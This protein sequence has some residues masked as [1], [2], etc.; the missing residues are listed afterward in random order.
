[1]HFSLLEWI[2][3]LAATIAVLLF[4]VVVMARGSDEPTMRRSAL[5]LSAYCGLAVCF[6]IWTGY[7]HGRQFAVRA[8]ATGARP[9]PLSAVGL[10]AAGGVGGCFG[11]GA[12]SSHGRQFAV[13]FFAG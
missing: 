10:W 11:S 8:R 13:Q 3:P 9:A 2:V 1:M 4:D 5:G 7:F 12:G 6:G